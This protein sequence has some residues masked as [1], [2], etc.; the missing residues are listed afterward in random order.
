MNDTLY[1]VGEVEEEEA[2]GIAP[3]S[4]ADGEDATACADC[5][6]Y[7]DCA[8]LNYVN[9]LSLKRDNRKVDHEFKCNIF[10]EKGDT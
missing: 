4:I 6:T 3:F 5:I 7:G 1:E 10:V 9:K 8:I 2:Q